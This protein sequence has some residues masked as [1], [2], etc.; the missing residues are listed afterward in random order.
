MQLLKRQRDAVG[1]SVYDELQI[2]QTQA[3]SSERHHQ[4]ILGKLEEI[5]RHPSTLKKTIPQISSVE[6]A[7]PTIA[8][9]FY[10][11]CF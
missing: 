5:A 10:G 7:S 2:L 11:G 4:F 8:P 6:P 9:S 3:K 1:L